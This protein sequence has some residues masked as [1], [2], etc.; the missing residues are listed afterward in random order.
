MKKILFGLLL[1]G[2]TSLVCC[3]LDTDPTDKYTV[4]TFWDT[5]EG[6]EAAMTGCYN[7]LVN[8]ALFGGSAPLLEE[9]CTPNAYNYNNSGGYNVIAQGTHTANTSGIIANRWKVCYEGIGRCNTHLNRL[10]GA[11]IADS[12]RTQMEGEAK[13]LRALYYYM[14]ITYYNGVPLILEEP[15]Y[16]H[17][18]LPRASRTAV[19]EAILNDLRDATTLLDWKWSAKDDQGRATRGAAMALKARLLLFEASKLI[20]PSND[21]QKWADAAAAVQAVMDIE[22]SAGYDLYDNYRELFLP[23]NEHSCECVFNVEF[24]K[25]KGTAVNTFNTISIQYRNNAPLLDLVL[26]YETKT[27][28]PATM[29]K[30]DNL[31]PRFA[32]TNFYPGATFLGKAN[33]SASEIC[34]FSGFAHKKLSIYD[35]QKRDSDD[36]NGE[37]N[38]QF[39]RYADILLMFA[40]AQNEVDTEPSDA[41]YDAINRVRK[42][43]GMPSFPYDSKTKEQ[44]RDAIRHERRIEFAGEGLYYN[45]IRRWMT[46]ELEM[47]T[48]IQDYAGTDIAV[49]AFD[50]DRDYWWPIPADQLLLNKKLEQNPN[51]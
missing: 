4:N 28:G 43:V 35:E 25:T 27:G 19:V 30:Y 46:A 18:S 15:I 24:S 1:C 5:T 17:G 26:S 6:T 13:F 14:L 38:Y 3:N 51:Y 21:A 34:Q 7:V 9:T 31:D 33:C 23:K 8:E 45:D 32:A 12:R 48:V 41:V 49:R 11:V 2:S 39:I 29:G 22:K 10:P 40:E 47:N 50:P 36:G 16:A 44:M 20:N 37:T 42:R